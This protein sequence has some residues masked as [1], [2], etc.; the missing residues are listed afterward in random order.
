ME[1]GVGS[2][3]G[4]P[5]GCED[6]PESIGIDTEVMVFADGPMM[7]EVVE[8][9][10]DAAPMDVD[11]CG[12]GGAARPF[13]LPQECGGERVEEAAAMGHCMVFSKLIFIE[14]VI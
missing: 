12:D 10:L 9:C 6:T 1:R 8:P 2:L 7:G 4:D 11:G 14:F 3:G 5:V 13:F